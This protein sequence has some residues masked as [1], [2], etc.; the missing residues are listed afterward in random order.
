MSW[1]IFIFLENNE[2]IRN[3][4]FY[5]W[6]CEMK[7]EAIFILLRGFVI[8]FPFHSIKRFWKE[9]MSQNFSVWKASFHRKTHA[10]SSK[11]HMKKRPMHVEKKHLFKTLILKLNKHLEHI[12]LQTHFTLFVFKYRGKNRQCLPYIKQN[13]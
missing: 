3:G 8:V 12:R 13:K 11:K 2:I 7:S 6:M 1:L 5:F 4:L 10:C 9:K